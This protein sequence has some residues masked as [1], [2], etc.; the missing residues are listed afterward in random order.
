[1]I[2]TGVLEITGDVFNGRGG[3]EVAFYGRVGNN[4]SFSS[5]ACLSVFLELQL[6]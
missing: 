5:T 4:Q 6:V 3:W 2:I 1:M